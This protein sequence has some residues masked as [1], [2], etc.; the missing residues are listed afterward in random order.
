MRSP[1]LNI[2]PCCG[3]KITSDLRAE[4]CG[5]CG[6]LAVGPPLAQ[7]EQALPSYVPAVF[8]G[9]SGALLA[10]VFLAGTF[11]A[12]LERKPFSLAF[13]N[14][15][16]A[17]ETAAWRLKW[18]ALPLAFVAAAAGWHVCL[19]LL[20]E[21]ARFAGLRLARTGF[22]LSTA[23]ALAGVSLIGVTVPER[24]RKRQVARDAARSAEGYEAIRVLLDYR[25]RY[26]TL[27]ATPKDLDKLADPDGAV[28]R[29]Q[30]ML[31]GGAYEPESAIAALPPAAAKVR[32]RRAAAVGIRPVALRASAE[33]APAE[34][35][36]FTNYKLV[37]PGEDKKL[38]TAD[39]LYI[40]DG[41][42]MP[43]PPPAT[44]APARAV[45]A[46]GTRTP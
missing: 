43:Q 15:V 1:A 14:I 11:S 10:A 8:I 32:G 23:V 4:A 46:G 44:L 40:R 29:V 42:I 45:S 33:V 25:A 13:W 36:T 21:P 18:L 35:L 3:S 2:C 28:A 6:A 20:R 9:A 5:G 12:L 34:G 24:L 31:R 26:G 7:P 22:V 16:A 30:A 39:D 41:V 17:G 38:G 19:K 37:L 27:P